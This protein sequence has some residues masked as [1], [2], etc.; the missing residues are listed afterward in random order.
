MSVC[1]KDLFDYD[2]V[3][4]CCRCKNIFLKTNFHKDKKTKDGLFSQYRFCVVQRQK[5]Y[6]SENREKILKRN[7]EY[8]LKHYDKI[9]ARKKIYSNNKSKTDI[10]FRLICKTKSGIHQVLK[11]MVKSSSTKDF[12]GIDINIYKR[13][14]E[15]Q[16]TP[17]M[18]WSNTEVDHAKPI[19]MFDV[20]NDEELKEAFNWK[21]TQPSLKQDHLQ[22]GIKFNFLDYQ[23]QFIKA[24][25]FLKLNGQEGLN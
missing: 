24:Y 14:I 25:Q 17:E 13:W 7:K 20:S 23:L 3:K 11:G 1:I 10:N 19:C 22:K 18:N 5:I 6:D 16:F 8:Q 2:L 15:W 21:N 4:K 12:L 9:V